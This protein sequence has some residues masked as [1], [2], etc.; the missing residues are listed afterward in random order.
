[1][2]HKSEEL[3][4]R[5]QAF[6]DEY[7]LENRHSPTTRTI[8]EAVGVAAGTA[9]KYLVAMNENG[10]LE[11]DGRTIATAKTAKASTE[12]TNVAILGSVSCGIPQL[13]EEYIEEY[14]SL[15]VS[16]FGKGEFFIVRANGE[17][18][19]EAG[20]NDGDLVVVRRQ[21]EA[22]EGQIIVALV[23]NE[24]TLKRFFV[25]KEN[26]CVRLHPENKSMEDIIVKKCEI[27][28]VA[29]NVIKSLDN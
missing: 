25:D 13:E 28:G 10:M 9:Y 14:V 7:Y 12:M 17:S 23:E 18:M 4:K 1:M 20:I 19:I 15:P 24:N 3:M 27:Q 29:V 6:V 22:R 5:I 21:S 11:Y 8:A 26:D 2:R 16:M